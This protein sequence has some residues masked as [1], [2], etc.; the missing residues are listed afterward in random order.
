MEFFYCAYIIILDASEQTFEEGATF[1]GKEDAESFRR[2][3]IAH[4]EGMGYTVQE[5]KVSK[6]KVRKNNKPRPSQEF[7]AKM[8]VW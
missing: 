5:S 7:G 1:R 4:W 8:G 6:R 2:S 3:R